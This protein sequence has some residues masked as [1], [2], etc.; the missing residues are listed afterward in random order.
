MNLF[1]RRSLSKHEKANR[2]IWSF[3]ALVLVV[4]VMGALGWFPSNSL[5]ILQPLNGFIGWFAIFCVA[6]CIINL[7]NKERVPGEKEFSN[8]AFINLLFTLGMGVGIMVYAYNESASLAAYD[9]VRNPIGLTL[10]HWIV[11]PWCFYVTFAIFEIYEEKYHLLPKWLG[12]GK[13][14]SLWSFNDAWHRNIVCFRRYNNIWSMQAHLW[15]RYSFIFA[16]CH[17]GLLSN[18]LLAQGH[19][20]GYEV[21]CQDIHDDTL[22]LY[23]NNDNSCTVRYDAGRSEGYWLFYR[24][25]LL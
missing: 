4:L 2:R 5:T 16:C 6:F 18:I 22:W 10:N 7:F 8:S 13:N 24:R 25:F 23:D 11:I 14:I 1:S 20:S 12:G 9:D 3:V 21:V 17:F 15:N 19:P